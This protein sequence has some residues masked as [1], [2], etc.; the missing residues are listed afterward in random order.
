MPGKTGGVL[1]MVAVR[2]GVSDAAGFSVG[3]LICAKAVCMAAVI[4]MFGSAEAG[5]GWHAVN[6]AANRLRLRIMRLLVMRGLYQ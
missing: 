4:M 2:I 1:T 3:I 6:S 5:E